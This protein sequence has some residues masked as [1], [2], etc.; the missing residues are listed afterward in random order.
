MR[1]L[2]LS[3]TV[4]SQAWWFIHCYQILY[5]AINNGCLLKAFY[6]S[7]FLYRIILSGTG[8]AFL[9][10]ISMARLLAIAMLVGGA[11][12]LLEVWLKQNF[13]FTLAKINKND[14]K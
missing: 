2:V 12:K 8:G 4:Y 6:H 1:G 14:T 5:T 10:A 13:Y 11:N 9:I 7:P 3:L